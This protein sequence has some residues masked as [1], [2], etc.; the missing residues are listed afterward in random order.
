MKD[1]D[2]FIV[3]KNPYCS[4]PA[5]S[6]PSQAVTKVWF[7]TP[8]KEELQKTKYNLNEVLA[9]SILFYEAQRSGKLDDNRKGKKKVIEFPSFKTKFRKNRQKN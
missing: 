5:S 9:K 6:L 4:K 2:L 7:K 1:R 8:T 3:S